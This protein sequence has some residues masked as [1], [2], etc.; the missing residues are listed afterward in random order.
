MASRVLLVWLYNNTG[1][2]V[3]A[4]ALCHDTANV[5]W[6]LVTNEG[7]HDDPRITGL[8]TAFAAAIV[9]VVWG[10]RTLARYSN[11]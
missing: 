8:I 2:S 6:L 7:S 10:P 1:K 4:A 3:F 11:A 5:S 9:T